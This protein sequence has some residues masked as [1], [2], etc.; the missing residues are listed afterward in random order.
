[1]RRGDDMGEL[2]MHLFLAG[3]RQDGGNGWMRCVEAMESNMLRDSGCWLL[4]ENLSET[5]MREGKRQSSRIP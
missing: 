4:C 1:M 3:W 5:R 2:M